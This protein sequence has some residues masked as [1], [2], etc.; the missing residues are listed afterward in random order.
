MRFMSEQDVRQFDLFLQSPEGSDKLG[1]ALLARMAP[2]YEKTVYQNVSELENE[3]KRIV[4]DFDAGAPTIDQSRD[5]LG[6]RQSWGGQDGDEFEQP[7]D[8]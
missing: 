1:A 7:T 8:Q 3:L 4:A 2:G 6:R 5:N